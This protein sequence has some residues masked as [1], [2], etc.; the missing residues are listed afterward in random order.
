MPKEAEQQESFEAGFEQFAQEAAT[1]EG[2]SQ[3]TQTQDAEGQGEP[4]TS[5]GPE[6]GTETE[7]RKPEPEPTE[8][9]DYGR[10]VHGL[11]SRLGRAEA[12]LKRYRQQEA[13]VR[14]NAA[15]RSSAEGQAAYEEWAKLDPDTA[16]LA[17]K[18]V[19]G[20]V[21]RRLQE[22]LGE[23]AG[24]VDARVQQVEGVHAEQRQQVFVR[25]VA[26]ALGD[27]RTDQWT[28]EYRTP[29][30][31]DWLKRQPKFVRDLE[32]AEDPE[33]ADIAYVFRQYRSQAGESKQDQQ[34]SDRKAAALKMSR[35]APSRSSETSLDGVK[36]QDSFQA[37][38]DKFVRERAQ[39]EKQQALH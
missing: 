33:P 13:Q 36:E 30:F 15:K 37:G 3:Q 17:D 14:E 29:E 35:A 2:E 38:F 22:A 39:R 8:T 32:H 26:Q 5:A 16:A 6:T 27:E 11:K 24:R 18:Y 7:E 9:H 34:A 10:E 31:Q 23:V 28:E 4:P 19:Q 25:N 1:D 21:E 12:E 20:L